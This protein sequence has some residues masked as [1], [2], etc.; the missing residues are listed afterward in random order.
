MVHRLR[1]LYL[2]DAYQ[3]DSQNYLNHVKGAAGF[4]SHM[5]KAILLLHLAKLINLPSFNF[6]APGALTWH[7]L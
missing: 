2:G 7:T 4:A 3:S 1:R 5:V 6:R